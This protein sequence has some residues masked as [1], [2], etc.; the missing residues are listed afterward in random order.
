MLCR[1][2]DVEVWRVLESVAPLFE[3][4]AFFPTMTD[5]DFAAHRH[6]IEPHGLHHDPE[7][8][9][10]WVILPVQA[11]LLRTAHHLVLVDACVGNDKTLPTLPVWENQRSGRFMAALAAAGACPEDVTHV[12][13]THLHVDH[14]GWTTSLKDGKWVPTFPNAKVLSTQI[15]LDH[16]RRGAETHP[17]T[18]AG[19]IW[20]QTIQPLLDDDRFE[21]V[22]SDHGIGDAIRFRPTPGHTPGHVS[23][24]IAV[25][26]QTGGVITGDLIHSP[27]Q[28]AVP[29]VSPRVDF[30]KALAAETR[31]QFMGEVAESRQL[32]LATHF[33][34]P[35]VGRMERS[36]DAFRWELLG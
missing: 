20:Q 18:N 2:G 13:C 31:T 30:D 33:P 7:T 23:V 24:E 17:D 19:F 14:V 1:I 11:F 21:I 3:I 35:S 5:E 16:A 25:P 34:L 9:T 22:G 32:I 15:D 8:G 6:M 10:D 4:R 12:M 27:I 26:K 28:C 36:G 29:E